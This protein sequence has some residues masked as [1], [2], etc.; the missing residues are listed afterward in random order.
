MAEKRM[1]TQKII[2][3]D[4]FLTM[5]L[6]A[7]A[8]YFHLNMRADDDGFV[9]NPRKIAEWIHASDDDL[10]LLLVKRFVIGFDSGIIVIKHWRMH[11][12]LKSDRYHPTDYQEELAMLEIKPNKAYTE[13]IQGFPVPEALPPKEE[14]LNQSGSKL[15]PNRFQTG[16]TG[17]DIGLGLDKDLGL[18]T[19][20]I[21]PLGDTPAPK[22]P[23][24]KGKEDAFAALAGEDET[25]LKALRDFEAMRRSIKRPMSDRA[26]TMLVGKLNS[27]PREEWVPI[28]EQSVFHCWQGIFPLH[29]DSGSQG[30]D[31]GR[32]R[33]GSGPQTEEDRQKQKEA[34]AKAM[35][36][37]KRLRNKINGGADE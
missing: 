3:S 29:D 9:N 1:F 27:F 13:K 28:L 16:T 14:E 30:R 19:P 24:A 33:Y 21:S 15:V 37:V 18:D 34:D 2:D 12:T 4:A 35:E 8:L 7:Q 36:Q 5:P 22:K 20:P 23:R 17:L 10:R 32:R 26:K 6:S 31:S 11:N 25:L